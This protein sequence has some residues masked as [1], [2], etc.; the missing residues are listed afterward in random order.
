MAYLG[1]FAEDATVYTW[2]STNDSSGGRAAFSSAL[3]T[4][5]VEVIK[6]GNTTGST[7]GV[8]ITNDFDSKTGLHKIEIDMSAD[9]FYATGSDYALLLYPDETIDG[10][11]V[12]AVIAEWSCENRFA[13]V[14][15]ATVSDKTGYRLSATGVD[16]IWDEA[17][18]GH[19]SAG[20]F[21]SAL[22]VIHSGTA[23]AGASTTI[24]LQTGTASTTDDFYND[25]IIYIVSGTGAGQGRIIEDYDG[26]T[27]QRATVGTWATNPDNTSV[28]VILPFGSIPGASAPT[29]AAV[30]DAVW[31]EAMGDHVSE[32]SFGTMLQSAHEG[33]AQAGTASSL[34]LDASGSSATN[35]YYKYAVLQIVAGTGVGQSRQIT[36]YDGTS[37]VATVDP[38][39]TTTPSTDSEYVITSLGIDAATL[40]QI[41]DAV[42]D[43][44]RSGHI[45][46]G[47]FGEYVLADAARVS[48]S[49]TAADGLEAAVSGGT[50]LPANVTQVGGIAQDLPT[51]TDMQTIDDNVDSILADTGTD[52]VA[53]LATSVRAALGMAAA[54]L[55]TQLSTIDTVA[56]N[57]ETDTQDIQSRLP[58]SLNN[59]AI[60]ADVQR[61]NDAEVVGDG[62]ATPWDGA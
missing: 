20:S 17:T 18:A 40:N 32:G 12:A 49:T 59:G 11:S 51:A 7:A 6:D 15:A 33:T 9:A 31:D 37:K 4:A 56:D 29:A 30:A 45:G 24:D 8:T 48:G 47:T 57:I 39:W 58:A 38:A 52:G 2:F 62:N 55:D 16:D 1:D 46:A 36:A 60:P 43:E 3:E 61:I 42:W 50:P 5:D 44:E 14:T 34:T 35:D 21:G 41:A 28:Y 54:D 25:Q 10:Q 19:L 13:E 23:D 53:V 27:N 26:V 22:Q